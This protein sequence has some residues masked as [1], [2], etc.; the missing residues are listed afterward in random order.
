MTIA[1]VFD[2]IVSKRCYK[3]AMSF[4]EAFN[5]IKQQ[6]GK[7]FDPVIT[8]AFLEIRKQIEV[9]ARNYR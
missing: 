2:A 6:R 8:D 3:E 5:L 9:I 1:D 4:D 7:K